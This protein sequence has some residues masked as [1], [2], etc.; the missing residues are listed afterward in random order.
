MAARLLSEH[1]AGIL[2]LCGPYIE[3]GR[4]LL[5]VEADHVDVMK[6]MKGITAEIRRCGR[7]QV[8]LDE[9]SLHYCQ[10]ERRIELLTPLLGP[11]I[12]LHGILQQEYL[13]DSDRDWE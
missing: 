10:A 9:S 6:V 4:F 7:M 13:E 8:G 11:I 2:H 1:N 3:Y 5:P 12:S